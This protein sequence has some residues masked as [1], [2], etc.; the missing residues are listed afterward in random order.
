MKKTELDSKHE[1]A[2]TR[3]VSHAKAILT[4]FLV[5]FHSYTGFDAIS[6]FPRTG[7]VKPL[8]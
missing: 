3:I 7:K 4:K 2:D 8:S 1:E 6:A 5:G